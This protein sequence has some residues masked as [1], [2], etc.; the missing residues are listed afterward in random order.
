MDELF[1]PHQR[2]EALRRQLNEHGYRYYVLNA[3][4]ITDAEY[5]R[6]YHELVALETAHPEVITPDSPTQRAGSDLQGDFEKVTHPTP[7]LSLSNCFSED[8]LRAW[9]ER[10]LKLLPAG[11]TLDYTLEPKLDGLTVVIT[12]ENGVLTRAATRGNGLVGDDVTPNVRTIRSVPLRIPLDPAADVPVPDRLVVRGEVLFLKQD[13]AALNARQREAGL[14][15]YV[16]ARNTASGTLKQKD[17]RITATRPLTAFLYN[18]VALDGLPM[19]ATQWD[20]LHYLRALGFVIPPQAEH[21]PTLSHIIQQLPTWIEQRARLP[22]EIDG[23]VIKVNAL[24]I[25]DELGFVGKDPRGATAYKFP[26]EEAKTRLIGVTHSVGR[27]GKLTPT[28]QLEPVF[29]GGV[30]VTSASLH[31]Y[32][33]IQALDIRQGDQVVIK[34]SGDVIPYVVGPLIGARVGDETPIEPPANCPFCASPI[35][36]PDGAVDYF[37][38]NPQCP[39][40]VYRQIEFFVSKGALD[41]EGF[42]GRTVQALIAR[43]LI[44]DEADI[45][46]LT[47]APLLELDKF[48]EKRTEN[49]LKAIDAAKH[50]PLPRVITALGIDGVGETVAESLAAHFG[51]MDALAAAAPQDIQ[52]IAGIGPILAQNIASFFASSRSQTLINKLRAAGVNLAAEIAAPVSD[53][54]A[55][56]TFVLT[57]TLPTLSRE[58]AEALIKS[59]GGKISGSVSKKTSYLLMGDSPGSK[60]EK[61]A[62]L[63]VP[64]LSE[65]DLLAMLA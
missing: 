55:G 44:Q 22:F 8:D 45:F 41:I 27:S 51:S 13:F 62:Q 4:S 16:N 39:E 5:D 3:P 17:S 18:I 33:T 47:A 43:G 21:Y 60:A 58:Q 64:I 56:Q 23:V 34:R 28:A 61:A 38:S 46:S 42:G 48:G 52:Q 12:Y 36:R 37:C 24:R 59:H 63:G 29:V 10:N 20:T 57:G 25:A 53:R 30:T 6:L 14:P 50:R 9:E 32:D 2:A 15:L 11:T 31:N 40:R 1:N 54:L 49:L 35:V 19:P 26:S 65:A 7:I